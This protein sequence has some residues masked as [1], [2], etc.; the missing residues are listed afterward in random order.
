M[1][2]LTCEFGLLTHRVP[3]FG[4][5]FGKLGPITQ[6]VAKPAAHVGNMEYQLSRGLVA[7]LSRLPS[8]C[9]RFEVIE[10]TESN[11]EQED[12]EARSDS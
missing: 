5:L 2:I 9:T 10:A 1:F 12:K 3:G 7:T 11:Q 4:V 8:G 6:E